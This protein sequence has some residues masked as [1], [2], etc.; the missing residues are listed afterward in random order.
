MKA[1]RDLAEVMAPEKVVARIA[2]STKEEIWIG[3]ST[4]RGTRLIYVRSFVNM[5]EEEEWRPT[6]KGVSMRVELYPHLLE[7]FEDVEGNLDF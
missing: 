5:N 7:A 4:Y 2:K 6:Q 1:V 3:V